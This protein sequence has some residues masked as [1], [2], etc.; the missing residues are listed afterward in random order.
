MGPIRQRGIREI[1]ICSVVELAVGTA[2]PCESLD[3]TVVGTVTLEPNFIGIESW[4]GCYGIDMRQG[5]FGNDQDC[6]DLIAP[7]SLI[8]LDPEEDRVL[9]DGEGICLEFRS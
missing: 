2:P 5:S 9:S 8:V 7:L 1:G 6:C 4:V 3:C